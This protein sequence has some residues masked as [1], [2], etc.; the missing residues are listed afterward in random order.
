MN[1]CP[2]C[3]VDPNRVIAESDVAIALRDKFPLTEGH[4]LIEPRRH[5]MSIFDLSNQDQAA[6]WVMVGQ[7]RETLL[8]QLSADGINIGVND[9][10]AAGQTVEHVHIHLIPRHKG[11]IADPRVGVRHIIPGKARYWED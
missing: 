8:L 2:F 9:G 6:M 7:V 4:T 3:A 11:D 10:F 1:S 5:V